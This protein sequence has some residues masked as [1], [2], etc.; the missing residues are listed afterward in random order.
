MRFDRAWIVA[1]PVLFLLALTELAALFNFG[2]DGTDF[3][4]TIY[5]PARAVFDGRSPYDL[6]GSV[7]P[8]SAFLPAI[9]LAELG[10][11]AA[12]TTWLLLMVTA[13]ILTLYILGVRDVR[14]YLLWVLNPAMLGTIVTGN[15]T[16]LVILCVALLWRWRDHAYRA[17]AC[18][19]VAICIKLFVAPLWLWLLMTRRY[20]A[21][22]TTAAAV[23]AVILGSWACIGFSGLRRYPGILDADNRYLGHAGPFLQALLL[24]IGSPRRAAL[25]IAL[26]VALALILLASRIAD[27][28]SAFMLVALAA[29]IASPV[30]W[31]GYAGVVL[32]AFAA[33]R[34]RYDVS[35]LLFLAFAVHWWWSPVGYTTAAL[36]IAT[37]AIV[38]AFV[39]AVVAPRLRYIPPVLVAFGFLVEWLWTDPMITRANALAYAG[40]AIAVLAPLAAAAVGHDSARNAASSLRVT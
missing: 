35:W 23:P 29:V 32:V 1:L 33:R 28:L 6:A 36:S 14:C 25:V 20:R 17:A 13:A 15:A 27:D 40:V 34:P 24:Q 18:L 37:L 8:P 3:Q 11:Y 38:S 21:A 31:P 4:G 22:A 9:P 7:Y 2:R 30:A 39:S 10:W 26:V 16:V 5:G 19:V 12:E